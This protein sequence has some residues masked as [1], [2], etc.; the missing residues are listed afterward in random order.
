MLEDAGNVNIQDEDVPLGDLNNEETTSEIA[1]E[2]VPLGV[3]DETETEATNIEEEDVPLA[4]GVEKNAK[5]V[6]WWWIPAIAAALTGGK[7]AYDK[8][9]KKGIF[10]EKAVAANEQ[11]KSDK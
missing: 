4:S 6:W 5:R 10:K 9:N 8:K 2:D 3:V 11:K 7:T 1:D